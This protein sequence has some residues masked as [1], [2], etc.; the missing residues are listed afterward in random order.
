MTYRKVYFVLLVA[1]LVVVAVTALSACGNATDPAGD[2]RSSTEASPMPAATGEPLIFGFDG[3]FTGFMAMDVELAEKGIL[4]KLDMIQNQWEGRPVEY[5]KADNGSDPV[6]A[7]D[8]ARQ[9]VESDKIQYMAGPIFS[10]SAAAVT[11]YLA[12]AGGIPQ[13]SIV[14]QPSDNLKTANDLAFMPNGLYGSQGY[15]FGKYVGEKLGYKTV[16][17]VNLEDTAARQLQAGFEK[18]LAE[19]GGKVVSLQYVPIDTIDFSSYLTTL[20]DADATY[21]WV[22]GNGAA[23]FVKQ[24]ND[25]GLT[26]PLIAPMSNNFSEQQLAD[27][28]QLSLN[29]IACDFY[30]PQLDNEAN[31]AFVAAYQKLYPGEYPPPQAY[32]GYQAVEL[33]LQGVKSSGGDTSP[34]ALIKA[35][36]TITLTGMPGGDVTMQPYKGAYIPTRDW[37]IVKTE[38]VGDRIAWVPIYT[39]EQVTLGE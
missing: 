3:G 9:L 15:Y 1:L 37:Y 5:K 7:V 14:G 2:S 32:G 34:A 23:P 33:F 21:F 11:D 28:G 39:Y 25:Y 12:K 35:M 31:K 30:S 8:K 19:S 4:T 26:A 29:M 18:G 20:K 36:S 10:P 22:F 17:C 6:Q 13:C 38:Q 24:Y 16:N 27:L